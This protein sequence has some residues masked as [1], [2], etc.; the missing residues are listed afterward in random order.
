M[1]P[2]R[3]IFT[4]LINAC[5]KSGAVDRAFDV[6]AEMLAENQPIEP[7]HA[8]VGALI[9]TC[10]QAGQADRAREVYKMLHRYKI[11]GDPTVYTIAVNSCSLTGDLDFALTIYSDM[12][13]NGINPDELFLSSI[14]DVAGH[15]GK[16]DVAFEIFYD[17]KRKGLQLGNV[18]YSSLMGACTKAKDWEKALAL[19]EEIKAIKLRPTVSTMNALITSLCDGNQLLK[20]IDIFHEMKKAGIRPNTIT[21][22]VLVVA[23]EKKDELELG[24]DLFSQMEEDGVLPN[25]IIC[26]CLTGQCLQRYE[27][28]YSLGE[29]IL[30]LNSGSPTIDCIWTTSAMKVYRQTI[31]AGVIPSSEVFSNVLGCLKF[32]NDTS[33]RSRL[34]ENLGVIGDNTNCNLYPLLDGFG[35]Y[36]PR[37]FAIFE[38]ASSLGVVPSVSL[39]DG[40]VV[41]D[42]RNLQLHTAEVYLLTVLKG[43]KHRLAAGVRLQNISILLPIEKKQ[44]LSAGQEKMINIS[45]RVGQAV[46]ALLRRLKLAYQGDVSYGKIRVNGLSLRR[47]FTPKFMFPSYGVKSTTLASSQSWLSKEITSQ[48]RDIRLK[49][50]EL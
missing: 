20:A 6:L 34:V 36:D 16:V 27:K 19:H 38:E 44:I 9:K 35:E 4:S 10:I 31:S 43:L 2:D 41:V 22:S 39:K 3:V 17:A 26:Q 48:Q 33:L 47:W 25:L 37:A 8:T 14:V 28:A 12:Q 23:C 1:K 13:R 29:P 5:G 45:G 15:A 11:K 50:F 46:A 24:F 32:P 21:Y 7:D 49:N 18:S 40:P 30:S 42:A